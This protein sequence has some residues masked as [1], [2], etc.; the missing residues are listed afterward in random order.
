MYQKLQQE[1]NSLIVRLQ[2]SE[3]LRAEALATCETMR[4][5]LVAIT[6][7]RNQWKDAARLAQ[8]QIAAISK[9]LKQGFF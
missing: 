9:R 1:R 2:E 6:L 8:E 4:Q 3:R 7:N 5:E